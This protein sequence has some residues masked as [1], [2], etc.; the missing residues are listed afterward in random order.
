MGYHAPSSSCAYSKPWWIVNCYKTF[1]PDSVD[2]RYTPV[3]K[4]RHQRKERQQ[5]IHSL[6]GRKKWHYSR[7]T[8]GQGWEMPV[9]TQRWQLASGNFSF[10]TEAVFLLLS[11]KNYGHKEAQAQRF[12]GEQKPTPDVT[13][14]LHRLLNFAEHLSTHTHPCM[15]SH[16]HTYS[17]LSVGVWKGAGT[18]MCT[19]AVAQGW[20]NAHMCIEANVCTWVW[21]TESNLRGSSSASIYFV[22]WEVAWPVSTWDLPVSAP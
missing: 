18:S 21:R 15:N 20:M 1:G 8:Q 11:C 7:G 2:S 5:G 10:Y 12:Q 14:W 13:V 9:A 4:N 19:H 3:I 22:F 17:F 16:A 6:S